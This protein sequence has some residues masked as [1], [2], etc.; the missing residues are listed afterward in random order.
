MSKSPVQPK[1]SL[2]LHKTFRSKEGNREIVY[3]LYDGK[4]VD[5][6]N[7]ID[8]LHFTEEFQGGE[9]R[10]TAVS[11]LDL[12]L[13]DLA[14]RGA[15][16]KY[17]HWHTLGLEKGLSPEKLVKAYHNA[18]AS[19][20]R[21][22]VYDT[23]LALLR[24]IVYER[25]AILEFYNNGL[26]KIRQAGRNQGVLEIDEDQEFQDTVE[27]LDSVYSLF[28]TEGENKKL[29]SFDTR[30]KQL[31]SKNSLCKLF[32]SIAGIGDSWVSAATIVSIAQGVERFPRVSDFFSYFGM[33]DAKLQRRKKGQ[34]SNWSAKGR[35]T[36]FKLGE[37]LIK[38][39]NNPWR[40][41]FE[42]AKAEYSLKH[43]RECGCKAEKGHPH[44]Q[45]RRKMVKE[46]LKRFY[47]A[48]TGQEFEPKHFAASNKV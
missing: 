21:N 2:T 7:D 8:I 46:I 16:I 31:A 45:A 18:P 34:P 3:Y 12:F 42:Q 11:S 33:G 10:V 37:S 29:V 35:T 32:N 13:K 26:R 39:K 30:I 6:L 5:I 17:A 48:A 23:E 28:K 24:R 38:N 25:D 41:Y 4:T 14:D 27:A 20:F 40:K 47:L 43:K 36:C 44:A 22:F 19:A 1:T 9:I 15:T